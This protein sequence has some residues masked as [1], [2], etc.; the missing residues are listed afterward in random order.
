MKMVFDQ[1]EV[2]LIVR[3]FVV[4]EYGVEEGRV[5]NIGYK[6]IG[7]GKVLLEVDIETDAARP[8]TSVYR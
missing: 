4:N 3:E 6:I 1:N 5:S 7:D 8:R 2:A